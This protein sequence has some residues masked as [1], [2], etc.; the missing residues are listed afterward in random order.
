ML[1]RRTRWMQILGRLKQNVPLAEALTGL[2]PWFKA[3]LDKDTRR[4]AAGRCAAP[5]PERG[6]QRFAAACKAG[7]Q[8]T[9]RPVS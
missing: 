1:D 4:Q 5:L 9:T 6:I 8:L 2:Q 3:M 7:A